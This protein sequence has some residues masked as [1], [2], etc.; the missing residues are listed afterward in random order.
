MLHHPVRAVL[1]D[2]SCDRLS[3]LFF[4]ALVA[5]TFLL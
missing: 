3:I 5:A 4:A 1:C 2:L